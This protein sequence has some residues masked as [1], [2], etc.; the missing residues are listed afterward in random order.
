MVFQERQ[1]LDQ[2]PKMGTWHNLTSTLIQGSG[3]AIEMRPCFRDPC[4]GDV[5][6]VPTLTHRFG[7]SAHNKIVVSE[8]GMPKM[9]DT[10]KGKCP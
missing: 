8:K 1:R 6:T 7:G 3:P 10:P 5:N 2:I 4:A 9:V